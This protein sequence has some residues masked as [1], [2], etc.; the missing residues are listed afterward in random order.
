MK[1]EEITEKL[2][3]IIKPYLPE[4]VDVNNININDNFTSS[5]GINSMHLVDIALDIEDAFDIEIENEELERISNIK[6]AVELISV[7]LE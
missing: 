1:S 2:K 3:D 4:D 7:K 6:E 5:I